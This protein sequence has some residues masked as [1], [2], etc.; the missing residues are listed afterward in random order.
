[1]TGKKVDISKLDLEKEREKITDF[2]GLIAFAHH[3]GSAL[4]KPEDQGRI[5]GTSMAAMRDQTDRQF[6]QIMDQMQVLMNQAH[7]LKRRVDV[8]DRIY[9][10]HMSFQPV[11]HQVYHLYQ[12]KDGTDFLSMIGPEEWGRSKPFEMHVASVKLLSDYTWELN[13]GADNFI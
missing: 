9:Q 13:S 1:M 10:S 11:I 4:I 2:P 5:K 6:K 12:R 3:V 8:S 7:E